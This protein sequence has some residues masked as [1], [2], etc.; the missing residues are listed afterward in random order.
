MNVLS[1]ANSLLQYFPSIILSIVLS[2]TKS[3]VSFNIFII[4]YS[5]ID[6]TLP[7]LYLK[8]ISFTI[9]IIIINYIHF[10]SDS[11]SGDSNFP[12]SHFPLISLINLSTLNVLPTLPI[13]ASS[14]VR[15]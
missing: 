7:L 11:E 13:T 5:G 10:L 3:V 2:N 14:L 8:L 1:L 4:L 6:V 9:Y 15:V 12:L